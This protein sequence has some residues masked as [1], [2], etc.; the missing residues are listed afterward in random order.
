MSLSFFSL[1]II[2][3]SLKK[4]LIKK[5]IWKCFPWKLI[6]QNFRLFS[7]FII[8]N[9]VKTKSN[10]NS[11]YTFLSLPLN[12]F[13]AT[14]FYLIK[15]WKKMFTFYKLSSIYFF[16]NIIFF[17]FEIWNLKYFNRNFIFFIM[18]R[19]LRGLCNNRIY[20]YEL[21]KWKKLYLKDQFLSK[22]II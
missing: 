6:K 22:R 21:R 10:I 14:F 15:F 2:K 4:Y 1:K 3:G 12:L 16:K 9:N 5:K 19:L 13:S 8:E 11:E 18:K 17:S 20:Y 7:L